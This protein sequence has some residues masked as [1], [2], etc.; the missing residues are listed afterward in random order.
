[1]GRDTAQYK[2]IHW[3]Q[4]L[5]GGKAGCAHNKAICQGA[6][7]AERRARAEGRSVASYLERLIL[8]DEKRDDQAKR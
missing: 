7:H 3:G 2:F 4:G 8:A 1:M 6:G 5:C